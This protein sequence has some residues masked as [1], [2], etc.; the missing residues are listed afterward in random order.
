MNLFKT[1]WSDIKNS[2]K[3]KAREQELKAQ[4]KV[5]I[6]TQ[7]ED[8]ARYKYVLQEKILQKDYQFKNLINIYNNIEEC[9]LAIEDAKKLYE[10][11]FSENKIEFK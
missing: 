8:I 5:Y 6:A 9:K 10:H 1:L 4:Y 7:E 3:E 11:I 2:F